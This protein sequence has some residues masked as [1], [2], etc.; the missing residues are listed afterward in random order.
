MKRYK[1]VF[2][3]QRKYFEVKWFL[4]ASLLWKLLPTAN[5]LLDTKKKL[6]LRKRVEEEG[7]NIWGI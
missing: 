1:L 6:V 5:F 2:T 3:T 4:A 7:F